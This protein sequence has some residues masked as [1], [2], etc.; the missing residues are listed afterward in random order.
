[1]KKMMDRLQEMCY[2]K[3]REISIAITIATPFIVTASRTT[4]IVMMILL[5][6]FFAWM[7]NY[8]K[9]YEEEMNRAIEKIMEEVKERY[10]HEK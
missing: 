5:C 6:V 3:L 2:N 9:K 8:A 10:N 7:Q 1:M 4:A